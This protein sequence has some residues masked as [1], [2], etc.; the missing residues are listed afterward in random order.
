VA[1]RR[2]KYFG[3]FANGRTGTRW[4][5]GFDNTAKTVN[6]LAF[7]GKDSGAVFTYRKNLINI[8]RTVD[9]K[10]LVTRLFAFG[11]D[12]M[13]FRG[14][15]NNKEY[16]EDFTYSN[17]VRVATLDCS[18]FTNPYQMLEF[19]RMRLADYSRPRISYVMSVMDLSILT[20]YEHEKWELGDIV[21][22]D[23]RNLDLQIKTRVIGVQYNVQ[24]PWKTVI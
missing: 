12:G 8:K 20:E 4:G 23:D 18:N 17:Q 14:V 21:T 15:N 10:S 5:F 2:A 6:L 3:C 1:M 24:E 19:T 16:V 11:R 9:T 13:T 22:V 7:S